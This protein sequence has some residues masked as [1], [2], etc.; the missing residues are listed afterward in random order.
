MHKSPFDSNFPPQNANKLENRKTLF[1]ISV[2]NNN[3]KR[4]KIGNYFEIDEH[5][6][7]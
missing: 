2:L 7:T 1:A 5:T 3:R 4:N 6:Q